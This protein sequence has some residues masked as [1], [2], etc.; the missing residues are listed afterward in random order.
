MDDGLSDIERE[1]TELT[2]SQRLGR[3]LKLVDGLQVWLQTERAKLS[4]NFSIAEAI[5]IQCPSAGMA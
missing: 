3:H 5:D 2:A 1:F 4:R